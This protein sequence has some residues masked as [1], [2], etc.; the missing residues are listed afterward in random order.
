MG[1]LL[2]LLSRILVQSNLYLAKNLGKM[3]AYE[4]AGSALGGAFTGFLL[5]GSVGQNNTLILAS[6]LNFLLATLLFTRKP[7]QILTIS[8]QLKASGKEKIS[9]P[10]NNIAHTTKNSDPLLLASISGFVAVGLQVV[11]I[12]VFK[13]YMTNTS[14]TFALTASMV[15][16]GLF[17]G[18]RL[19]VSLS[20]KNIH[21]TKLTALF[22]LSIF[23]SYALL[24]NLQTLVFF[25]L[26]SFQEI[27]WIRIFLIPLLSSILV[28]LPVT[29]IS[30]F[31]F[32]YACTLFTSDIHTVNRSV[33]RVLLFNTAGSFAGP[34]FAAFVLI[35][36]LGAALSILAF[37]LITLL[38][39]IYFLWRQG[40]FK[41]KTVQLLAI[42]LGCVVL[43]LTLV[44]KPKIYILPP[45]FTKKGKQ[46]LA[47]NESI[48]GTFVV[49]KES[50]TENSALSTYVNNSAVIGSSYDAI[51]AVK[52]VGH[53]P[54]FAGLKCKNALV[55]GFGIGVTTSAIASHA[56]VETIDCVELVSGLR[57]SAHFYSSL[58]HNIAD[59]KRLNIIGGDGR[60]Y[61]QTTNKKYD[62][63]SSDPTH[64]ILGSGSL[65]TKEYFQL[66]KNHL[67]PSG[68]VS[69][70]L[71]IHKMLLP[72]LL[73]IIKT[74][75]AV[76]P[77]ATV[78]IGHY[79][80]ILIGS[81]GKMKID[82]NSWKNNI[83]VTAKDSYFYTN[84]YHLAA[85]LLLD[86]ND[87]SKFPADIKI[88]EDNH[89]YVEFFNLHSFDQQN[90]SKNLAYL[91]SIRG[92]NSR[93]FENIDDTAT[94]Q[95]FVE[96][97]IELTLGLTEMLNKNNKAFLHHL[98]NACSI[99]PEDEEYPFLIKFHFN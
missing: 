27:H 18:S 1:G 19:Y 51:K 96:G 92:A 33:G 90:S 42:G 71:P 64:P 3:Y 21:L 31:M 62:L 65:Y 73:G 76:F 89:S 28:I 93:V 83:N 97:N 85:C 8:E 12:R 55:V 95:R 69:Q 79:H 14:Y 10:K 37:L 54:F 88:N 17:L 4:T 38:V 32:P 2:P 81:N 77:N 46:I 87:I 74:F 5:I 44:I 72:D 63:I 66:C 78:W 13:V 98:Q 22:G 49:G 35:P 94:M 68:M 45:S 41:N 9:T 47:Y 70:Y 91:N 58:N 16:L 82:F 40:S 61:L 25:P 7:L 43:L 57:N 80:L 23:A 6:A 36:L 39:T 53:L 86:S 48:E 60:H 99:N 50:E 34:L 52:M 84:P 26:V 29:I 11:W 56:E 20:N 59:D 30:G 75:H 15:I 24:L 67:T